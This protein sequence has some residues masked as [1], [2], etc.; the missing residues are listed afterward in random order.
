MLQSH[1]QCINLWNVQFLDVGG[2]KHSPWQTVPQLNTGRLKGNLPCLAY[3]FPSLICFITPRLIAWYLIL[4]SLMCFLSLARAS[5]TFITFSRAKGSSH[6]S[7]HWW[8]RDEDV[9]VCPSQK[10]TL[11]KGGETFVIGCLAQD[12]SHKGPGWRAD[13]RRGVKIT[14]MAIVSFCP[15]VHD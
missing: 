8:L 12:H 14:M 1:L 7:F 2:S 11:C 5:G 9:I 3:I 15:L 10:Q 6:P 4:R 13:V